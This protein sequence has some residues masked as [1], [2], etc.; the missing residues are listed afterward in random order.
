MY[1]DDY[2]HADDDAS[3]YGNANDKSRSLDTTVIVVIIIAVVVVTSLCFHG[4]G[5]TIVVIGKH[6]ASRKQQ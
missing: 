5:G 4:L 6:N 3:L 2:N 1:D